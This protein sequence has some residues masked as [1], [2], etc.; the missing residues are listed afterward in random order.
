[1]AIRASASPC[2]FPSF[3]GRLFQHLPQR[4]DVAVFRPPGSDVDFVKRVIGLPGDTIE[5][6]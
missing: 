3:E 6:S 1:M 2:R 5:V 4:G